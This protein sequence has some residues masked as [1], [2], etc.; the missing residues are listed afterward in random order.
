MEWAADSI[1]TTKELM[2]ESTSDRSASCRMV[3]YI[4]GK[5]FRLKYMYMYLG[6]CRN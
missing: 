3:M 4:V 1:I 2:E 6:I 5:V